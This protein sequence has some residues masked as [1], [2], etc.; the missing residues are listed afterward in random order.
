MEAAAAALAR[1]FSGG[2]P[3]AGLAP[4][5]A[6]CGGAEVA[7]VAVLAPSEGLMLQSRTPLGAAAAA[8][9][10]DS[11]AA[12]PAALFA[13]GACGAAPRLLAAHVAATRR[14][15]VAHR[16]RGHFAGALLDLAAAAGG[17]V[18]IEAVACLPLVADNR[19]F[20]ALMLGWPVAP[21]P[22]AAAA[23][24][25]L[26]AA[27]APHAALL[28]A[29]AA[30]VA[31]LVALPPAGAPVEGAEEGEG[32][33]GRYSGEREDEEGEGASG[34]DSD[35]SGGGSDASAGWPAALP[36]ALRFAPPA[37]EAR[38]ARWAAARLAPLDTTA[39]TVRLANLAVLGLL[40]RR[41]L[42]AAAP[43]A[44]PALA[45]APVA[46][47]AAAGA[48]P[49]FYRQHRE[50][51]L[52]AAFCLAI[53]LDWG[54]AA[55]ATAPP[56]AALY[57]TL[58]LDTA[59][60]ALLVRWRRAAP[61]AAAASAGVAAG[62]AAL[63]RGGGGAG[64]TGAGAGARCLLAVGAALAIAARNELRMRRTFASERAG[65]RA[66]AE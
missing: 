31:A 2:A 59:A 25:A 16:A 48:A 1:A 51:L 36:S 29:H 11:A 4:L 13:L 28:C 46:L 66:R 45:A 64:G 6:L 62:Q 54:A 12:A 21:P 39:A 47:L 42:A 60:L 65:R 61:L 53:F 57:A 14:A 44:W 22:P 49:R 40:Q 8:A 56:A 41:G 15:V 58:F 27:L 19:A 7:A 20:G 24:A 9:G 5:A 18:R 38:Y 43:R 10:A 17:G 34:A 33:E 32:V 37:R 52:S 30:G 50:A 63:Q 55:R 35:A 23:A 3:G 26:A